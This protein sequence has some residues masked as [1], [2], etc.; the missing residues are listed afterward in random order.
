MAYAYPTN[1]TGFGSLATYINGVTCIGGASGNCGLFWPLVVLMVFLSSFVMF[2]IVN[3]KEEAIVVSGFICLMISGLMAIINLVHDWYP[4]VFMI[5]VAG[6]LVYM[7]L[8]ERR[9]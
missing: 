8:G 7:H 2:S 1:V 9:Y 5:I 6:G 3:S 4:L